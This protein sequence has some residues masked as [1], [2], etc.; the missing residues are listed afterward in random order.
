MLGD[1]E[2][3]AR[4]RSEQDRDLSRYLQ[5]QVRAYS[6]RYRPILQKADQD[7]PVRK[8]ADLERLPL[9]SFDEIGDG[10]D[11]VLRP[12]YD[13]ISRFGGIEL[14][15]KLLWSRIW[16]R[17]EH[18]GRTVVDPAYKPV[19]WLLED[20]LPIGSSA[21][22]LERL[23][24][25]GRRWLETAG[26][27]SSDVVVG[28]LPA[29]PYLPFWELALGSRR[30]GLSSVFLEPSA[31]AVAV[32]RLQP[33]VLVGRPD[34]LV[35]LLEDAHA[36]GEASRLQDV[37][38]IIAAGE[39]LEPE[40]R[41]RLR[42]LGPAR[43]APDVVAA[44]APLGVRSLW[45][46]C[47]GAVGLHTSP[48]AEIL[49]VVDGE[50]VWTALGWSGTVLV[51]LRTGVHGTIDDRACPSCGRTTPRVRVGAVEEAAV[52]SADGGT[53]HSFARALEDHPGVRAWQ[54]ELRRV[55]GTDELIV[56][57]AP[58]GTD[59]PG[60]VLRELIEHMDVTQFVILDGDELE[61]RLATHGGSKIVD[62]R[63][64]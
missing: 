40:V 44:W 7:R 14:G 11:L 4:I 51:R 50:I 54:A 56:F 10:R 47:P 55:N 32:G 5:R 63:N 34:D 27:V 64:S 42:Q 59:H 17:V 6:N 21:A 28:I 26:V 3:P 29:G 12:D 43:R 20:G 45:T 2:R 25:L 16:G 33:T 37:R 38:T 61:R 36:D 13:T 30:G 15:A 1:R 60:P 53:H 39:P 46:E 19:H 9:T 31:S 35:R 22:D 41:A 57:L 48:S 52:P 24:E 58:Q 23:S 8:R 49:E 62:D 18:L